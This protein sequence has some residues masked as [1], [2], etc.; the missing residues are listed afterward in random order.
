M[1]N[2]VIGTQISSLRKKFGLTQEDL[3]NKLGFSKQTVSNWE[4]GLKTP[5]MGAIQK[6]A[7]L[8]NVSKSFII[9]GV[10]EPPSTSIEK[11]Y[12]QLSSPRQQKVYN[13]ATKEL[14]EQK[15]EQANTQVSPIEKEEKNSDEIYTL[16]AHSDDPDKTY[17]DE[18]I[19]NIKSVLAK[20]RKKYEE[21]HK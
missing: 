16:A 13:F 21:K 10:E 15:Q 3:A 19:D 6:M 17:T 14:E 9:E 20:A 12:N 5:R 18:E 8:F 7:D 2:N 1:E 4:T 11:I